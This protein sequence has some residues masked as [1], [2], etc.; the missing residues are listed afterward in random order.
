MQ[1]ENSYYSDI[2]VNRRRH[3]SV[4]LDLGCGTGYLSSVLAER[5]GHEGRVVGVDPKEKR[6]EVAKRKYSNF[7]NLQFVL[8]SSEDLPAGPYDVVFAN[9]VMQWIKD[10]D[11]TFRNVYKVLKPGGKFA[12]LCP[13]ERPVSAW[14][15]SPAQAVHYCCT[16]EEYET[17]A[18]NHGFEVEFKSL[19]AARYSFEN[20]DKLIDWILATTDV[21]PA[22][23][24]PAVMTDTREKFSS[25]PYIDWI[26][27]VFVFKRS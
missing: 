3:S 9:Q 27:L 16:S 4:V 8:G 26:K 17:I 25:T 5:V 24:D 7:R 21:D 1:K 20:V 13:R 11:S 6:L 19:E 18:L 15:L 12:F 2:S 22:T 14:N 10:K 23:V